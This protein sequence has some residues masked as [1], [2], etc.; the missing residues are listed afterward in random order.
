[1]NI[2]FF[3]SVYIWSSEP[4]IAKQC[5][6]ITIVTVAVLACKVY[7]TSLLRKLSSLE[8]RLQLGKRSWASLDL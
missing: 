1:M 3:I 2:F 4:G 5:M 7:G 8:N 6:H